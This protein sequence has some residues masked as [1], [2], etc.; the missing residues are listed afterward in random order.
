MW[1]LEPDC[2][3]LSPGS[4]IYLRCTLEQGAQP[5]CAHFSHL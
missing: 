3:G 2:L 4:V 1:D 5:V